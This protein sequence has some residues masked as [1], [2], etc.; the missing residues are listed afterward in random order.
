MLLRA[1]E[2]PVNEI[3]IEYG[4]RLLGVLMLSAAADTPN[5]YDDTCMIGISMQIFQE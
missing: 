5:P 1:P 3:Q 4:F 2:L